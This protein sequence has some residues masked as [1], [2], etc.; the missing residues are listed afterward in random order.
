MLADK[1]ATPRRILVVDDE[2]STRLLLARL[3]SQE[4]GVDAQLA[5]TCEQA[6]RLAGAQAYD[7]ILLDLM[8][9]GIG[10]LEVLRRLRAGPPNATTPVIVVSIVG[11]KATID[12]C[13]SAGANAY[14]VKPIRRAELIAALKAQ[15][16]S[17]HKLART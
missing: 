5:G 15:L 14:H 2:E 8:M 9:P 7:A 10:G 13:M 3:V 12:Q 1:K 16:E 6:L 4:L 17:R 11:E